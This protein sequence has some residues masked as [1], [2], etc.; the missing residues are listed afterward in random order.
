MVG[1]FISMNQYDDQEIYCR[2]LGHHLH[3]SY[4]HKEN[5][6][7]PCSKIVSCWSHRIDLAEFLR[8][9]YP[10]F[11]IKEGNVNAKPKITSILDILSQIKSNPSA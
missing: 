10:D 7:I 1:D 9:H 11:L 8:N 4:C 6:G 2:K 3:F 5:L